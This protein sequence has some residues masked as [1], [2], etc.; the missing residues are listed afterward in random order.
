M[1]APTKDL[2][3]ITMTEA[4]NLES[5]KRVV[6]RHFLEGYYCFRFRM[7]WFNRKFCWNV[8]LPEDADEACALEMAEEFFN[9]WTI[10]VA[11]LMAG[12][13]KP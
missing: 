1:S 6:L 9:E 13:I 2:C 8:G 7:E 3:I 12:K 10:T 11:E 5:L 4:S